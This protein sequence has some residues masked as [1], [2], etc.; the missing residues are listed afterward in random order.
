MNPDQRL[1]PGITLD[2]CRAELQRERAYRERTYPERIAQGRM[3]RAEADYQLAILAAIADDALRMTGAYAPPQHDYSWLERRAA[4]S[5]E[6]D[7]RDR[8]YPEWIASGRLTQARADHQ[9]ACLR[10]V[11]WRFDCG[12]DWRPTNGVR[13]QTAQDML[14]GKPRTAAQQETWAEMDAIWRR[15]DG[16]FYR[17]WPEPGTTAPAAEPELAL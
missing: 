5:R 9:R 14:D 8:F 11:L 10:A 4:L 15:P 1:F 12:F 2:D 6:I 17:R 16:L 13:D 7:L 3:T